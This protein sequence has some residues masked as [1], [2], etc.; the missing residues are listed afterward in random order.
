MMIPFKNKS[1]YDPRFDFK[2]NLV[3]D[4]TEIVTVEKP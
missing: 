1:F 4:V 2:D 3:E